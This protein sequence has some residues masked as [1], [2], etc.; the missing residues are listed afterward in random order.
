LKGEALKVLAMIP[1][2]ERMREPIEGVH[3]AQMTEAS[4]MSYLFGNKK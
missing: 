2:D 4:L 3:Y 1:L